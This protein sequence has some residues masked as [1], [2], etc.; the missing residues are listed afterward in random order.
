MLPIDDFVGKPSISWWVAS[1]ALAIL[2]SI[3]FI[4]GYFP[5]RRA[6]NLNV[7]DCIHYS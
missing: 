3:G 2:A 6:A 7:V 1:V 4:A 5:A